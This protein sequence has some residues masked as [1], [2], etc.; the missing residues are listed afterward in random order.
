MRATSRAAPG[1]GEFYRWLK[2]RLFA[3]WDWWKEKRLI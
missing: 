3:V 1:Q 2:G